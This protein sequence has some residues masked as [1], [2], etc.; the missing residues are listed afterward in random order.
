MHAFEGVQQGTVVGQE[1]LEY[2]YDRYLRGRPAPARAGQRARQP[3]DRSELA[4]RRAAPGPQPEGDARPR[5]AERREGALQAASTRAHGGKAATAGAFVAMDPRNGE[6][7]ALGSYAELR[8]QQVRQTADPGALRRRSTSAGRT[9]APLTDR[10]VDGDVSDRLDVQADHRDGGAGS[11]V[12]TPARRLGAG[13][14]IQ[15]GAAAFCNAGNAN[16]G[17]RRAGAR[18]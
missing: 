8:P 6:V 9:A 13:E 3:R 10:A 14:C 12:I 4:A 2:Y 16:Y 1:G 5:P 11:G 7:L 18:R 17:A 15:I